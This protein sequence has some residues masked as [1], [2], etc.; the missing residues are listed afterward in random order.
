[1]DD[2]QSTESG[3]GLL[4]VNYGPD[5]PASNAMSEAIKRRKKK[6]KEEAMADQLSEEIPLEDA[7]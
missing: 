2:F 7:T 5:K 4:K 1:M 3:Q 6:K